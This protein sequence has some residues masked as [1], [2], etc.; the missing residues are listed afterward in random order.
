MLKYLLCLVLAATFY[1]SNA[2]L[3][4]VQLIDSG[5]HT[6]I[7]GMSLLANG[8]VWLSGSNGT[9]ARSTDGGKTFSWLPVAGHEQRDFRDIHAF[10]SNTAIIM[11]IG[12]PAYILK[13][14]NGGQS[15]K[16]VFTRDR[17]GLFLDAMDFKN[18]ME[19]MCIGDPV[20]AGPDARK[21][22]YLLRTRDGGETWFEERWQ[23]W[24]PAEPQE[25]LFAASGTNLAFLNHP[26][27]EYAFVT[28][29]RVAKLYLIGRLNK[30][31]KMVNTP[32]NQGI[33][34]T[35]IFS[36]A[37]DG[38]NRFYCIG[39]DYAQ[40]T[41]IYSNFYYSTDG[42]S[43]WISP[44]ADRPKGYRS[45]ISIVNEKIL[46]ACGTTGVDVSKNGGK[47]WSTVS[48]I[49]FNVCMTAPGGKA[50]FLAGERGRIARIDL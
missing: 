27:Y 18:S 24:P 13:T 48:K 50:I 3:G 21:G 26:D 47:H 25:V 15:W 9:V 20:H 41:N 10:D 2:Q 8:V 16:E 44:S 33:L 7:R 11:G 22:F 5:R 17:E 6:S 43:K 19:G 28:G 37:T 42:G 35:G 49:G 23:N 4:E 12:N 46:I 1:T 39:G 29:G 36:M 45:C 34:T 14:T 31:S 30:P 38:M 32:V 40:P